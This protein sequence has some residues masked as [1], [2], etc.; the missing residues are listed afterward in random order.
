MINILFW[1][2]FGSHCLHFE[3]LYWNYKFLD[4]RFFKYRVEK[5]NYWEK[6]DEKM[7]N[8]DLTRAKT[9]LNLE[10]YKCIFSKA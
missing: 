1:F 2:F 9:D 10:G 4:F 5:E 6:D 7:K 8:E 3:F